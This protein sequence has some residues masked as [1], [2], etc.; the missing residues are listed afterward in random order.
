MDDESLKTNPADVPIPTSGIKHTGTRTRTMTAIPVMED[1]IAP[2]LLLQDT[3]RLLK[4]LGQGGMGV[5]MHGVDERLERDVA[6]KFIDPKRMQSGDDRQ[7]FV[8]EARAMARVRHPNLVEIYAFG[9][10]SG[11]PFFVMELVQGTDLQSWLRARTGLLSLD[12]ALG[13]LDQLCRGV[14]AMHE[15]GAVHRDLKPSN[16]LIGPGFRVAV[17][18]LGLARRVT[19]T[20]VED[21]IAG[22]P[23]YISPEVASQQALPPRYAHS[24]DVYALGIMAYELFTGRLPFE[25]G[26]AADLLHKHVYEKPTAPSLLRPELPGAFDRAILNALAK[27]P[28][29]RTESA[30]EFR[31][32]L[33]R[34]RQ[35]ISQG[36]Q[37]MRV[38]VADDDAACRT[39]T[40]EFIKQAFPGAHV[41][42]A[43]D[44]EE[45]LQMARLTPPDIALIDLNMPKLNGV[46]LTSALAADPK[47]KD[48]P[49]VVITGVGGAPDWQL[50]R[51]LGAAGFMVKPVDPDALCATVRRLTR[52]QGA[53]PY[54]G[55]VR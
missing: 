13:V 8:Q 29:Q 25:A 26:N 52:K 15:A 53:A 14:H 4:P 12:E 36:L 27:D 22:T 45:A 48:V 30:D 1:S 28:R 33:A 49:I 42:L 47:T 40:G 16:V 24:V 19:D 32:D 44:G 2:G 7:Q 9:E 5:V 3:Y 51:H 55:G 21:T 6:I 17:A 20:E 34:A 43:R 10:Y 41:E 23:A 11:T 18:D 54:M 38:L 31:K 39:W 50:L 46:E 37:P 35:R